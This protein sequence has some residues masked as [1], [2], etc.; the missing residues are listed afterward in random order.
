MAQSND[1][2]KNM[3]KKIADALKNQ[4]AEAVS[5]DS[6][7]MEEMR[8]LIKL[9]NEEDIIPQIEIEE[10]PLTP[11]AQIKPAKQSKKAE[12]IIE[13]SN[14]EEE[15]QID[16]PEAPKEEEPTVLKVD[17]NEVNPEPDMTL[18]FEEEKEDE[19]E[20]F[21][22]PNN[23]NVL[24]KL[25]AQLP[26]GVPKTTGALIIRQTIEALGIP[27]KSVLQDAQKVREALNSSIKD[28]TFTIQ[29]YKSNIKNLEKQSASYQKQLAKLND[30]IGL[31]VY[32]DK[33]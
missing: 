26:A 21:E 20:E 15:V 5:F 22:M 28:C 2:P 14:V 31:F 12:N 11:R 13:S 29:E 16:V 30:I 27:M 8:D 4:D 9:D 24:K 25:I 17:A 19:V 33:K 10:E 7:S 1:I 3:G 6:L 23:I 32:S 18:S